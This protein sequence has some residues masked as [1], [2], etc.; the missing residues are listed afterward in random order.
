MVD[1]KD[2]EAIALGYVEDALKAD[3]ANMNHIAGSDRSNCMRYQGKIG[4]AA[5]PWPLF[6]GK[7]PPRGGARP[8]PKKPS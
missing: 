5:G 2:S 1:A 3:T 4:E 8:G 7:W 6:A